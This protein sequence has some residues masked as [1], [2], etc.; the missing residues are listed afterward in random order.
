MNTKI[1]LLEKLI[2][3]MMLFIVGLITAKTLG[4]SSFGEYS[5]I[6]AVIATFTAISMYGLEAPA[7]RFFAKDN[8]NINYSN[9]TYNLIIIRFITSF[10]AIVSVI[11][12]C[13]I[14]KITLNSID[15][16]S[17]TIYMLS[18]SLYF[19]E[20]FLR[21]RLNAIT[22]LKSSL[23]QLSI[24]LLIKSYG[25][26][27]SYDA[28][29]FVFSAA[30]DIL[31]Y[32]IITYYYFVKINKH[33]SLKIFQKINTKEVKKIIRSST[34]LFISGLCMGIYR[35]YDIVFLNNYFTSDFI[36]QYSITSKV[37]A[38]TFIIPVVICNIYL[39]KIMNSSAY[40]IIL[41]EL[42]L[43]LFYLSMAI[44]LGYIFIII[45]S[46]K[47]YL[48]SSYDSITKISLFIGL[49]IFIISLDLF[50]QNHFINIGKN[51]LVFSLSLTTM[52]TVIVLNNLLYPWLGEY[53]VIYVFIISTPIS[54]ALNFFN[55][56]WRISIMLII[57]KLILKRK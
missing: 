56:E 27:N 25:W 47:I 52:L 53:T 15:Y 8:S 4:A 32:G 18:Y 31:I 49:Y 33:K 38:G 30:L 26:Y 55:R 9:Y 39:K 44:Y 2:R 43:K 3:S 21:S 50:L 16:L 46:L 42:G 35:N 17:I 10:I 6:I 40:Y 51:N 41:K 48:G 20:Y 57:N 23:L 1:F 36:G 14:T 37:I 12:Y 13:K 24:S 28:S 7:L 5:V 11:L 29:Y 45:P 54:I 22:I 34:P 19:G